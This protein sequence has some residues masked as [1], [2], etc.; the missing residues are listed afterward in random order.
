MSLMQNNVSYSVIVTYS[1]RKHKL[2]SGRGLGL[3]CENRERG[4]SEISHRMVSRWQS[5]WFGQLLS[6]WTEH[7][8]CT[9]SWRLEQSLLGRHL[10]AR[11]QSCPDDMLHIYTNQML[12]FSRSVI[13][14][15]YGSDTQGRSD[16]GY[17]GIYTPQN[18]SIPYKF[19]CDYSL[20]CSHV[21]H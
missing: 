10:S 16:G 7:T 2:P 8:P 4:R 15:N 1:F 19:F 12:P 20:C 5:R 6:R 21:G 11:L 18:Q 9:T 17:I 3:S 14:E 13:K